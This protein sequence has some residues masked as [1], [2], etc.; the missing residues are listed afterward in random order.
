LSKQSSPSPTPPFTRSPRQPPKTPQLT[1]VRPRTVLLVGNPTLPLKG[2]PTAV[3]ALAAVARALPLHVRWVCQQRP[4]ELHVPGLAASE[5][6]IEFVVAPS[7]D[8]LPRL[9]RGHD[10]FLFTSRYEAW[11]MPVLE[12]MASGL[13]VVTTDCLGTRSFCQHGANCLLAPPDDAAALARHVVAVLTDGALSNKLAAAARET[14]L[15]HTPAAAA[16]ALERVLY[17]LTACAGELLE[18]RQGAAAEL[19]LACTWAS[20]ACARPAAVTQAQAAQAQQQLLLQTSAAQQQQQQ[21]QQQQAVVAA[22]AQQ[23]QQAQL[24]MLLE[25]QAARQQQH[26]QQQHQWH[27]LLEQQQHQQQQQQQQQQQH[28]QQQ[29]Q[30]Q[31]QAAINI[32]LLLGAAQQQHGVQLG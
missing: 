10:A 27:H 26:Q 1:A 28:Q 18:L 5:L 15:R 4:T 13:P 32:A 19:Q 12:A 11:G 8:D 14:A 9:Y 22:L 6:D 20:Y 17:A 31:Q 2:F 21:Q 24:Q 29:Q 3:A 30:Q 23:S 16:A 7:Q 25:Q